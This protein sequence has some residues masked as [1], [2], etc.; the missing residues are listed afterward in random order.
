[1][2]RETV[3]LFHGDT[4]QA[5]EV[6]WFP[7]CSAQ[8]RAFFGYSILLAGLYSTIWAVEERVQGPVIP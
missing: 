3:D 5:S 8:L 2:E 6:H 4:F 1:M 7:H